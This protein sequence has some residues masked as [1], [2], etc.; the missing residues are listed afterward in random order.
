MS[1][2]GKYAKT[3]AVTASAAVMALATACSGG[4]SG[5]GGGGGGSAPAADWEERGPITFATGKDT[6]GQLQSVVETWN[7]EHPEEKVTVVELPE[8]ADEQ[9][10]QMVNNFQVQSDQYTVLGMDV[11][12]TAEFAANQWIVE[13][14]ADKTNLDG[15]LEPT[16]ETAT[17]FDRTYGVPWSTNA[18]LLYFRSDLLEAAGVSAAPTTYEEMWAAC[19]K[20]LALPEAAGMSCYGGQLSKYEGLTVNASQ[21]VNSAGGE[22]F[23]ADGNPTV[24]TPEA[25]AG[26]QA[27]RDGFD[28]GM[29][30]QDALTYKEEESRQA[31]QDGGLVFL[32][33]WPYVYPLANAEDGSSQV[34]GKT[35]V[36]PIPGVT[37]PGASTLG[38]INLG[39]SAFASNKGTAIDF[40][41]FLTSEENQQAWALATGTAPTMESVF[42][43]EELVAE[44]EF[45]PI[46]HD[47]LKQAKGRPAVVNYAGV[48]A[49]IQDNA[50]AIISGEVEVEA[51]MEQLQADLEKVVQG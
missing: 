17:Y 12:W 48:S 38:G 51:G 25:I 5:G 23:D 30:P 4:G 47:A 40:I 3:F 28:S 50:Y 32:S 11:V 6:T 35:G 46:L 34:A 7:A 43:D 14:P 41:N 42:S 2:F 20:V 8:S 37:G 15:L 33:N 44:Y 13:M 18:Q 9:R 49:A 21:A 22:M 10:T 19:E 45:Y 39:V 31:F 27:L 29:I 24:T 36:A 16:V 1:R 26:I